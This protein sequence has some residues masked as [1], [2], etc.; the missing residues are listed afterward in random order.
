[1]VIIVPTTSL[2]TACIPTDWAA[3]MDEEKKNLRLRYPEEEYF[4]DDYY[5]RLE[6][7]WVS[8][9]DARLIEPIECTE[10]DGKYLIWDGHH[11]YA[12]SIIN[13]ILE[14]PITIPD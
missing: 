13:N 11:R 12:L 3:W 5:E 14:V 1:M 2:I 6:E 8:S 7:W 10:Q 4:P 9:M